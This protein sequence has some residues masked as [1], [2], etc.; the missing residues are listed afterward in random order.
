MKSRTT[1]DLV[2]VN[3]GKTKN[4]SRNRFKNKSKSKDKLKCYPYNKLGHINRNCKVL[5]QG[6]KDRKIKKN[7]DN[8]N[9]VVMNSDDNVVTLV[10]SHG[11]CNHVSDQGIEW[12]VD[13]NTRFNE[14]ARQKDIESRLVKLL[15][16]ITRAGPRIEVISKDKTKSKGKLKYY[17]YGKLVHIKRNY[18]VLKQKQKKWTKQEE[19]K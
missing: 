3:K 4:R 19:F 12:I 15:L 6:K 1:Q 5:K 2:I 7:L 16:Q 8:N 10:Y 13:T 18:K 11:D 9:V 14:E 17:H